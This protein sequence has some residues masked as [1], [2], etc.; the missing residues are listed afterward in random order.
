M[1][2]RTDQPIFKNYRWLHFLPAL[3]V[4]FLRLPA[5]FY[6]LPELQDMMQ[7][8]IAAYAPLHRWG[9]SFMVQPLF[10][11]AYLLAYAVAINWYTHRLRNRQSQQE[12]VSPGLLATCFTLYTLAFVAYY[13]LV[14]TAFF[15]IEH[16]YLISLIMAL[17]IYVIGYQEWKE[18]RTASAPVDKPKYQ[19]SSLTAAAAASIAGKLDHYMQQ[20]RPYQNNELRLNDLADAIDVSSHHLSQVIND[21]YGKTFNQ[22]I[23]EFRIREAIQLLRSEEH[24]QSFIIDIAYQVGFNNKTT[25]NH[26]FKAQT[27]M[28]PSKWRE[29][30]GERPSAA[31]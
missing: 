7:T 4:F 19:S 28:S 5:Y 24:R 2:G 23:N 29:Y 6:P 9:L 27:G 31:R 10:I 25:F 11:V 15:R 18:L 8:G 30:D 26:A 12:G 22:Y 3:L 1:D 17:S 21:H 20:H 16:D 14:R 13:I